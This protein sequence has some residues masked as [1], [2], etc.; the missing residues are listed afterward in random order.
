MLEIYYSKLASCF[1]KR[2]KDY[3][4]KRGDFVRLF[5]QTYLNGL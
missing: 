2:D 3:S 4:L 1:A 5:V